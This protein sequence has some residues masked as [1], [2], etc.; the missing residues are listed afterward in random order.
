ML[1]DNNYYFKNFSFYKG[2]NSKLIEF[3]KLIEPV[4]PIE[5]VESIEPFI[6]VES[7]DRFASKRDIKYSTCKIYE[8]F[9]IKKNL[10]HLYDSQIAKDWTSKNKKIDDFIKES[11]FEAK[12]YDDIIEWINFYQLENI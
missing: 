6:P 9:N 2:L 1:N 4:E 8:Q 5:S 12:C 10:Y 11:Q 7:F 3:V